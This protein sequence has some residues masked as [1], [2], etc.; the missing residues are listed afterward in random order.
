MKDLTDYIKENWEEHFKNACKSC[1][2]KTMNRLVH[3]KTG[4]E[5]PFCV[6]CISRGFYNKEIFD[7]KYHR[8]K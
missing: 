5:Y 8:E 7:V 3:K 6:E 4:E 1:H 2:T